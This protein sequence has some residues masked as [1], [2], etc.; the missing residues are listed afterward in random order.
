MLVK[1]KAF[2]GMIKQ[3]REKTIELFERRKR[4]ES[5]D[6]QPPAEE[7]KKAPLATVKEIVMSKVDE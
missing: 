7:E 1:I 3:T 6:N 2:G 5:G 4:E